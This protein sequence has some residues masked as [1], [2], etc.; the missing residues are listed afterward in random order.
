MDRFIFMLEWSDA[1]QSMSNEN[2]GIFFQNVINYHKGLPLDTSSD[3]VNP[4]FSL[5]IPQWERMN[6]KYQTSIEN[7][8]KGG[9]PKGTTPW[10]KGKTK[11]SEPNA[12]PT[13]TKDEPTSNQTRNYKEKDK[14]KEKDN[15]INNTSS[16]LL[17]QKNLL[18]QIIQK[19]IEEGFEKTIANSL[20]KDMI[21]LKSKE[22]LLIFINE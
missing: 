15:N 7:G 21:K 13:Q 3:V 2:K 20:A 17:E 22:E 16:I 18:E 6:G 19:F 4:V 14:E 11:V 10:N 8:K 5:L 9:A 1:V 12:N